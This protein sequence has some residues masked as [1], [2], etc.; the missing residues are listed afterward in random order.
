MKSLSYL[1]VIT[2]KLNDWQYNL[3]WQLPNIVIAGLLIVIFYIVA[4]SMKW[5]VHFTLEKRHRRALAGVISVFIFW[6]IILIGLLVAVTLI[7]PSVQPADMLSTLGI[8]SVAFGFAFKDIL[9]NLLSGILI[10]LHQPFKIGDTIRINGFEGTVDEI[11]T[12]ATYLTSENGNI[13]VIPNAIIYT[14]ALVVLT[15]TTR[16]Q[17]NRGTKSIEAI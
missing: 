10:L 2:E 11:A 7:F 3:L 4:K 8:G 13:I 1:S 17:E 14:G 16:I 15:H 5:F 6:A 9:Q 12:R